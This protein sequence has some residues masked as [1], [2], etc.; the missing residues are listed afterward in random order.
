MSITRNR[1]SHGLSWLLA[2]VVLLAFG[3]QAPPASAVEVGSEQDTTG[4]QIISF[5]STPAAVDVRTAAAIITATA[6]VTDD[7]SGLTIARVHYRSPS[8]IQ[9]QTFG[10]A[11][12]SRTSGNATDGTYS[13]D[14]S[15]GTQQESGVWTV[16]GA[17]TTDV[18]G[19]S[20]FYSEAE[21]RAFG[22]TDFTVTSNRDATK[23]AVTAVRWSPDPL[24]ASASDVMPVFEWDATDEGGSGVFHVIIS[25]TSPSNRQRITGQAVDGG[26]TARNAHTFTAIGK[27]STPRGTGSHFEDGVP[28]YSEPGTWTVNYVQVYDRAS[29]VTTYQGA[30]LEAILQGPFVVVADP[31]DT[32]DPVLS[33]YRFSPS[34]IDVSTSGKIVDVE[35]DV[36][37][38]LSG[39]QAAWV[40]FKSPT[41]STA[42]PQYITR[43]ASYYQSLSQPRL[44][45]GT[46]HATVSF[47]TYDRSGDWTVSQVCVVDEVKHVVCRTGAA[48][49]PLGPTGLNVIANEPPGVTVTGVQ[50][51]ATYQAGSVP[52]AGCDVQDR[53]DGAVAG[54]QPTTSGPDA[55]GQ[56]TA[57][58]S[59]TDGGGKTGTAT[60]TYTVDA[61]SNTAPEVEVTGVTAAT[62]E[63]GAEPTPGCTVSDAEDT[64]E[65]AVPTVGPASGSNGLGSRTVTCTYTDGGGLT[66]TRTVSYTVVDTGLPTLSGAPTTDPNG[67]GWYRDD[68]TIHWTAGDAGTGIDPAT[69]PADEVVSTEGSNQTRTASVADLAGNTATATSA[70]AVNIDKTAPT[71][72]TPSF[73]V[74]PK[75]KNQSTTLSFTFTDN[76]SGVVGGE[77]FLDSDPGPGNGAAMFLNTAGT[78]LTHTFGTALAPGVYTVG[79]R[80]VDAAGNWSATAT[81]LL[82]VYDPSGGFVTGGGHIASPAGALVADPAATGRATFGFVSKYQKGAAT[83]TGNTEFQF[84]AG[85]LT[86]S[87]TAYD[88]LVISGARAQYKGS[89]SVNGV[90]GYKFQLTV[91]DGAVN[92]GGGVDKFRIKI[93]K[94]G[95]AVYDNMLGASDDLAAA[96]EVTGGNIVI[97]AK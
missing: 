61:P 26:S 62:Y 54:V 74:N 71:V 56:Y 19:N 41:I 83:P 12:G 64:N 13:E 24:D 50:D 20:R 48:L 7:L 73:S 37:D 9:S 45:G 16:S 79:V 66:T 23:P 15:I 75:A 14:F 97:H 96:Q 1:R 59:Y 55:S 49:A 10:F 32:V 69:L 84:N 38:E 82:V 8:G 80:S 36:S 76:L 33:A 72:G 86:F 68:V 3:L 46:V 44:M 58:C 43:T 87:S 31:A 35:I 53:E 2:V 91:T 51:G 57:T 39:V 47:P 60:V 21:A 65:A 6:R 77:Y 88:W 89:G 17:T 92:G 18:V 67:A 95:A 34:S 85:G 22:A 30:A 90:A 93:S 52:A 27:M 78:E 28:Q 4:P 70:P 25:I 63:I 42:S 40:S 11:S 94:D 81:E 29:N 5:S